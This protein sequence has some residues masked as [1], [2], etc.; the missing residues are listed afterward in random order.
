MMSRTFFTALLLLTTTLSCL[1]CPITSES[2][3]TTTF[4]VWSSTFRTGEN[5][6]ISEEEGLKRREI[7]ESTIS[8]IR[9]HNKEADA[10]MHTYRLGVNQVYH[11]YYWIRLH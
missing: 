8:K 2:P 3:E 4:E 7:F 11:T 1:L 10:G 5:K 6:Y 9:A